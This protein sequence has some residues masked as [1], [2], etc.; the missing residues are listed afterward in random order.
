[1]SMVHL[2]LSYILYTN[3]RIKSFQT[4][5][6]KNI[7]HL[8][9]IFNW[10]VNSNCGRLLLLASNKSDKQPNFSYNISLGKINFLLRYS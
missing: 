3:N 6:N 8:P 10:G 1:M 7:D 2:M 4:I 5:L 9:T